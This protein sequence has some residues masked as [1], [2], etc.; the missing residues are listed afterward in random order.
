[1]KNNLKAYSGKRR[2]ELIFHYFQVLNKVAPVG[3]PA[4]Y[5]ESPG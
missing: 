2:A 1:M 3:A 4:A 5:F